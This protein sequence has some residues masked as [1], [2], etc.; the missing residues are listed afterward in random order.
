M[1]ALAGRA[2]DLVFWLILLGLAA[3]F[4]HSAL[5]WISLHAAE[6]TH[7]PYPVA[8]ACGVV[9]LLLGAWLHERL[10]PLLALPELRWV[11]HDR[12]L[13]QARG[14]TFS[15]SLHLCAFAFFG[16]FVGACTGH[17]WVGA[18][19]ASLLRALPLLRGTPRL[20]QLLASGRKGLVGTSAFAIQ[21]SEFISDAIAASWS[22]WRGGP[23]TTNLT[24][25]FL[26]RLARRSYLP[27]TA[28]LI[29]STTLACANALGAVG[30]FGFVIAWAMLG[31]G[32]YRCADLSRLG[33]SSPVRWWVLGVHAITALAIFVLT[34]EFYSPAV[35]LFIAGAIFWTGFLRGRPR[36]TYDL[37]SVDSGFGVMVSPALLH[38]YLSGLGLTSIAAG[39]LAFASTL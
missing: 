7:V 33:I 36:S 21:D 28:L 34:W 38:Y 35:P 14:F 30:I 20:P 11:Y 12:P 37:T 17:P 13:G 31:A 24:R 29:L 22:T 10:V 5:G 16:L 39:L 18:V 6:S 4:A 3:G 2:G 27:A 25:L 23:P 1:K 19:F 32:I 9:S 8:L 15:S 26:R